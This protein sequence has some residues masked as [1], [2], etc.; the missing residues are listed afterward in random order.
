M[1]NVTPVSIIYSLSIAYLASSIFYVGYQLTQMQSVVDETSEVR[2]V[3]PSILAEI[4]AVREEIPAI[5]AEVKAFREQIP[6]V[7]KESEAIR[8]TVPVV[9]NE[10]SLV[11][12]Q[13]PSIIAT[14]DKSL[15]AIP[16]MLDRADGIV[17]G[18]EKA[19]SDAGEKAAQGFLT[20]IVTAPIALVRSLLGTKELERDDLDQMD[21]AATKA[22][23]ADKIGATE[24]WSNS[25]NNTKGTISVLR[26]ITINGKDCRVMG[27]VSHKEDKKITN[28]EITMCKLPSGK[29]KMQEK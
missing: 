9:V 2:L 17:K 26:K 10:V 18:A 4:K 15:E 7:I 12:K 1:K 25:K 8:K 19:G 24:D 29:W 28:A 13:V 20:G 6:S 21:Q 5:V 16:A 11:R 23:K 27:V 3:I 14:M 22:L